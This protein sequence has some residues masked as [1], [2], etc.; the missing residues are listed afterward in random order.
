MPQASSF[1]NGQTRPS[2][3]ISPSARPRRRC[4]SALRDDAEHEPGGS[5]R[6]ARTRPRSGADSRP[7]AVPAA[8]RRA[9]TRHTPPAAS[10]APAGP[11]SRPSTPCGT[12]TRC[13]GLD[14]VHGLVNDHIVEPPQKREDPIEPDRSRRLLGL[15]GQRLASN[16]QFQPKRRLHGSTL[17]QAQ[18]SGVRSQESG[19]RS[20]E[21]RIV[22][23]C[24]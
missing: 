15:D 8:I 17:S 13:L 22:C 14:R 20:Q 6:D 12:C 18:E 2:A 21:G 11:G 19:V 4:P 3:N 16:R 5:R 9:A 24:S 23:S 10:P 7:A 1:R